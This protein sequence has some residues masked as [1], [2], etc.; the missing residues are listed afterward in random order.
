MPSHTL[1]STCHL[2]PEPEPPGTRKQLF[3]VTPISPPP[4]QCTS[5]GDVR[6]PPQL[7]SILSMLKTVHCGDFLD[8]LFVF[9]RRVWDVAI[10]GIQ[11]SFS[12]CCSGGG[13]QGHCVWWNN[14]SGCYWQPR[15]LSWRTDWAQ[16]QPSFSEGLSPPD[17]E[18]F[19]VSFPSS[20]CFR[21][22]R[23]QKVKP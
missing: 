1:Y 17:A 14:E 9:P 20:G 19:G 22:G 4:P 23:D 15:A 5:W 6:D 3:Q 16:P 12:T 7:F 2:G 18:A 8:T 11:F 13:A 21:Q 10:C